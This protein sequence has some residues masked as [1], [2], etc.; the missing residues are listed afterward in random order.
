[1]QPNAFDGFLGCN[2]TLHYLV[3]LHVNAT[4]HLIPRRCEEHVVLFGEDSARDWVS[5]LEHG[6]THAGLMVP[7]SYRAVVRSC[8]NVARLSRQDGIDSIGVSD[9]GISEL[10][11]LIPSDDETVLVASIDLL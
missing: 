3:L 1:M 4:D 7:L 5:E 9:Q 6:L 10:T 11:L 2:E 8:D